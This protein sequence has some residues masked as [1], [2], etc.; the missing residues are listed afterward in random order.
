[1]I[2]SLTGRLARREQGWALIEVGG[3]GYAVL[4]PTRSL[5]LLP[6]E[7]ETV[8][9]HTHLHV[10]EGELAL[11]GFAS[12][13][14]KEAFISL[15]GVGGVGPKVALAVLS[16]LAPEEL[17]RA[18]AANDVATIS[19][20]PGVGRKT[21]Q[22]I[23]VD[24]ADKMAGPALSVGGTP[25]GGEADPRAEAREALLAMGFT[26]TEITLALR[27]APE[28]ATSAELVRHALS[29]LGGGV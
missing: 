6:S 29:R 4:M 17:A 26:A 11:Y 3:V 12:E 28:G 18:I 15:L 1:M 25:A 5:A 14:E 2:A 10:R 27:G 22:R 21:A 23:C 8:V 19:S 24:L 16:V 13:Q 20:V 7:G 9:V